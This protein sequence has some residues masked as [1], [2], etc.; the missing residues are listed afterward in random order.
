MTIA[1]E[2][3][4]TV[5]LFVLLLIGLEMVRAFTSQSAF[6]VTLTEATAQTVT[7][8]LTLAGELVRTDGAVIYSPEFNMRIVSE[9]TA[10][11]PII[12]LGAAT[13]AVRAPLN[14]K[15]KGI[16]FGACVLNIVNLARIISLY[17][18]GVVWPDMV[19][20]VHL[21]IWQGA[22]VVLA[23]GLWGF[24]TQKLGVLHAK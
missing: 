21:V 3:V 8:M 14:S 5:I 20:F 18:V 2:S 1:K 19:E 23:V 10:I 4:R 22:L 12:L 11:T 7:W 16:M 17:Y 15:L 9:C 6:M 24:W 13:L